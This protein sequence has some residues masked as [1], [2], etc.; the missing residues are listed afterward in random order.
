MPTYNY[1]CTSCNYV[2][3]EFHG[4]LEN[5]K[6][7]CKKCNSFSEKIFTANGNFILK[8]NHWPSKDFKFK[9]DMTNKNRKAEKKQKERELAGE[10]VTSVKDLEK[11]KS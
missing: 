1:Q 9:K 6:V 11:K 5:P 3:E 8:G 7:K 10:A 4:I 2:Q